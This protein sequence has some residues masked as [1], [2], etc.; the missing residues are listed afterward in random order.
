MVRPW[1]HSKDGSN[2][3]VACLIEK[4]VTYVLGQFA[5]WGAGACSIP[6]STSS[7]AA[8]IEY[9]LQDSKADLILCS[10]KYAE[11]C[12]S[13]AENTDNKPKVIEITH[14][15][16]LSAKNEKLAIS[17]DLK[18]P[19]PDIQDKLDALVVYTSGTTGRPKGVVHTHKSLHAQFEM[20]SKAWHWQEDDR[21]LNVLP[22]H[23]VHGICAVVNCSIWNGAECELMRG[24]F[25][26]EATW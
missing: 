8:E 19:I 11:M 5:T 6:L 15:S 17:S 20:L 26:S 24:R 18:A 1:I 9:Y 25:D 10:P 16:M 13:I 7:T 2:A 3:K 14:E 12:N 22:L 4:D 23:H 21:I